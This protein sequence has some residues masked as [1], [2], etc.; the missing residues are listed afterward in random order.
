M[1]IDPPL[2]HSRTGVN[3]S[4]ARPPAWVGCS[5]TA[6]QVWDDDPLA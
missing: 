2:T 6:A 3:P 4:K 5:H 1:A